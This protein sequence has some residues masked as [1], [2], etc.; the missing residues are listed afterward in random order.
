M[1]KAA[2]QSSIIIIVNGIPMV[3]M[4]VINGIAMIILLV[5]VRRDLEGEHLGWK[6]DLLRVTLSS[7]SLIRKM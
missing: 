5:M 7:T 2:L 1:S 4:N 6:Y 3:A